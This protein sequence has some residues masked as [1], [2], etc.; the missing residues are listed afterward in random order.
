MF[1][2]RQR[3]VLLSKLASF[4]GDTAILRRGDVSRFLN[5]LEL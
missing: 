2:R 3:P 4:E 1:R 5:T